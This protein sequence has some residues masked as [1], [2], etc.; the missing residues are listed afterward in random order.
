MTPVSRVPRVTDQVDTNP[1]PAPFGAVKP[2][3]EAYHQFSCGGWVTAVAWSPS[4]S[5]LAYAGESA[6]SFSSRTC[7]HNC[8]CQWVDAP[9]SA[10]SMRTDILKIH[11]FCHFFLSLRGR[12]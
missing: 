5:I 7:V 9:T 3:G 8:N 1:N 12:F 6:F 4:G 11:I 2:F 10:F